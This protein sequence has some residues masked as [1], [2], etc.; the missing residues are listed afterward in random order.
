MTAYGAYE[1]V[2]GLEVHAQLL[3]RTK[4]FCGCAT[5]FGDPPNTHTCPVCLGLPGALPVLNAEAVALAV[6][7]SL[8]LGCSIQ[9]RSVFA[10]KNYFYPDLPKGYQISQ[11]DLP[12]A[13]S[14][15]L[16][17]EVDGA[18]RRVG[19]RRIHME[20]DAGKN[21]HGVGDESVVDLNRAGTPL[22]EIVS[23]PDLRSGAEAAEYLRRLREVLMFTGVNDGN[24]EQGS[25]RCDA[26]VSIRKVGETRLGTRVELKNI[27][28]FKFV[29]DAIDVEIRRQ[30]NLVERG[31]RVRQQTRGYNAEKRESYLL[32][33]KENESDYRYFPEPDLPPL[34]L[35]EAFIE[36]VQEALPELPVAKR[37]R[38]TLELGLTAYQAGVL[39]AHPAIAWFFDEARATYPDAVKLANF[40]QSEVLRDVTT[41]G[42]SATIPVTPAQVAEILRLVD[43]GTISGKQAK[44]LYAA[45][46]GTDKAPADV[47]RERGMAVL[48]DASAIEAIARSVME[49]NP[50]QVASYRAGKTALLGFFVGQIMKQTKG[51]ADPAT[52][53][54]V[55]VR[56]L[57]EGSGA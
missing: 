48:G 9:A 41:T 52:V 21:L 11:Y 50:K 27:N 19:I 34:V 56:L 29:A 2:I 10:R 6:R 33:D 39:G 51:S 46:A 49:A 57:G 18:P 25:F 4:A 45:V 24:L 13:L 20:E 5:S 44:E 26:N 47:V 36:S 17:V 37:T 40:V 15:V 55:L 23:E 32:R 38:W 54:A 22:I 31:E 12:L 53:N 35:E 43:A 3:T 8:A 16:D 30:V 7:A 28:S 1:P 14:G 42:L